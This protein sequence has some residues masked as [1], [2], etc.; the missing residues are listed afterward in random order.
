MSNLIKENSF[1]KT[2]FKGHKDYVSAVTFSPNNKYIL[3]GSY[4]DTAILWDLEGNEIKIFEGHKGNVNSVAFSNN[5]EYILTGSADNT[6]KLWNMEGKE[7]QTFKGHGGYVSSVAFSPN[8]KYILTGSYDDTAILWD[9]EGNEIQTFKGHKGY[10]N[11]VAFSP[12]GKSIL[13][14]SNDYTAKLWNMEENEIQTFKGHTDYVRSVTFSPDGKYILTGSFDKTARLWEIDTDKLSEEDLLSG[15][16]VHSLTLQEKIKYETIDLEEILASNEVSLLVSG[17]NYFRQK[18]MKGKVEYL[19]D[20]YFKKTKT[21][22]ERLIEKM[23]EKSDLENPSTW[24]TVGVRYSDIE[25][26]ETMLMESK[27]I[28]RK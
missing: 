17:A 12:D 8:G 6:A 22:Y 15:G 2:P 23:P 26:I 7:I 14:G 5:G 28:M 27:T 18:S 24:K 25:K 21:I 11:S 9:L 10:V 1:Y 19:K 4:D 13:T 16:H 3:T 20:E